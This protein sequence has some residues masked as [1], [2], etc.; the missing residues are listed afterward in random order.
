MKGVEMHMLLRRTGI[1]G[2]ELATHMGF[3]TA[4]RVYKASNLGSSEV[5]TIY[6]MAFERILGKGRFD[7][8]L[9]RI[10]EDRIALRARASKVVVVNAQQRTSQKNAKPALEFEDEVYDEEEEDGEE[11]ESNGRSDS[12]TQ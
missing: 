4:S 1:K 2:T 7:A 3:P 12:E 10:R 9:K 5:P 11:T 6:D 8:L